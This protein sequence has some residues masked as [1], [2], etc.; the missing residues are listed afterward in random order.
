MTKRALVLGGGGTTGIAWMTGLAAALGAEGIHLTE[1][2]LFIGTS[3]G[4]VV[5]TQL[6]YGLDPQ[7]L[8]AAQRAEGDQGAGL[9]QEPDASVMAVLGKWFTAPAMTPD[10][11]RE[12]GAMAL[13]APTIPEESWIGLFTR[14]LGEMPWPTNPLMITAVDAASGEMTTWDA[15]AG[16]PIARAIASS[17]AVPGLFPPVTINGGRYMDGGVRSGTN[18]DLAAGCEKILIIAPMGS[19]AHPF[20]HRQLMAELEQLRSEGSQVELILPDREALEVFGPNMMDTTRR[21]EAIETGLR[22]G[23]EAVKALH[24]FWK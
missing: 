15:A 3:A 9:S 16:V 19:H 5:G 14:S 10:L 20:G 7:V 21:T 1:A 2:D 17:C 8:L 6:A 13:T 22:Q 24:A 11:I 23:K 12:I 18:A 4:S